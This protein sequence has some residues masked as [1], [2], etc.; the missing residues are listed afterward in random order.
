MG[1]MNQAA[2]AYV[3]MYSGQKTFYMWGKAQGK[4]SLLLECQAMVVPGDG[5]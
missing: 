4:P 2:T 3:Y 5:T 1:D